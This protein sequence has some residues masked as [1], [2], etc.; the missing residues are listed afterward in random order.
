M[1]KR[2]ATEPLYSET[3][4]RKPVF[5]CTMDTI[6]VA[7]VGGGIVGSSV[8]YHLGEESPAEVTVFERGELAGETTA[9]S[10]AFV[11]LWGDEPPA[12]R[13]L[14]EYGVRLYNEF[15]ADPMAN[16]SYTHAP[17]LSVASTPEGTRT[18]QAAAGTRECVRGT[19]EYVPGEQLDG[20]LLHP[21]LDTASVEGA[22]YRPNIG[23]LDA[24]E[25][26]VEF[27]E[28]A[29][30][31]GVRF[32]TGTTVTDVTTKD[33]AVTG[34]V[35]D[36]EERRFDAVVAA[37]GPWNRQVA[38]FVG[39]DVPIRHT[40]GPILVFEPADAVPYD[41]FSVKHVESGVYFRQQPDGTV[42]AGHYPGGY[43]D[44][45]RVLDPDDVPTTVPSDL[46]E[47]IRGVVET[48][49]PWVE[50]ARVVDEW[51][52]VRSLTPDAG[53]IAG[54]T[55]VEGFYVSGFNAAGIQLAPVI[56]HVVAAQLLRGT[57]TEYYDAVRLSRFAGHTDAFRNWDD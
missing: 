37:A 24:T 43:D 27:V 25:L 11:G 39:L 8:A 42:F 13:R 35:A 9:A 22:L 21:G 44:A 3:A 50:G 33:G 1:V 53:A 48:Y 51:V 56:G 31:R 57:P 28:R 10:G 34:V 46:R 26:A 52:G 5:N 16:S 41:T 49:F 18:L 32:E 15:L 2:V 54:R 38:E 30:A 4:G 45:G 7:V 36:G 23:F 12:Y 47:K 40:L 14:K 19:P 29:R 20:E 17:R 6:R 55:S